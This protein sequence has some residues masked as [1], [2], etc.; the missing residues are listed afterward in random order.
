MP[1]VIDALARA[2]KQEP[3]A[4]VR[5]IEAISDPR[6]FLNEPV[7]SPTILYPRPYLISVWSSTSPFREAADAIGGFLVLAP[8]LG[9]GYFRS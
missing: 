7:L 5:V 2:N 3:E 6:D 1:T 9:I 8:F 4:I